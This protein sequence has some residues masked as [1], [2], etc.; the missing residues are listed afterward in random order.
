MKDYFKLFSTC[1]PVKGYKRSAIIDTQRD[2]IQLI[3]NDLY[4]ILIKTEYIDLK[5]IYSEYDSENEHT[6]KDYF[7]NLLEQELGFFC[8]EEEL[9][10]FPKISLEYRSPFSINNCIV[11]EMYGLQNYEKLLP[12]LENIG[13]EYL[14][15][16]LYKEIENETLTSL[17]DMFFYSSIK[18]IGL[19]IK[20]DATKDKDF[21]K[22]IT[23]TKLRLTKII[24]HSSESDEKLDYQ[25]Y[26][27]TDIL[28]T[29]K[30]FDS[31][32]FCGNV[33]SGY[34]SLNIQH[35]TESINH[36]T[37]LNKKIA[38]DKNG[39][40]K[41]CPAMPLILGN[42]KNSSLEDILAHP[43]LKKYWNITKDQI[44]VC[45]DCEFRYVCT[46]CRA[47]LEN[48]EDMYS[49]PLKCGYNPYTNEWEEWSAN[50]LKQKA[51]EYYN[52]KNSPNN[53]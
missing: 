13:C 8:T 20:Y 31:F 28:F 34:F 36:N 43:H 37:C 39:N 53:N 38:I 3:P 47:Y 50:P 29:K 40:I 49:K 27:L 51:I 24:L 9:D 17:L 16:I 26:N 46:D 4:E 11:E 21:L 33:N 52:L 44:E 41:N 25:N 45:K 14:E 15:I 6:I 2:K 1:L 22:H 23:S 7:D 12:Q 42:I 48:P 35:F 5:Q 30:V 10:N 32:K 19:I 18:N